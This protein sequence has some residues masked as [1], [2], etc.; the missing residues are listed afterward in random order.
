MQSIQSKIKNAREYIDPITRWYN[1]TNILCL[2][3]KIYSWVDF[4]KLK[5]ELSQKYPTELLNEVDFESEFDSFFEWEA[6]FFFSEARELLWTREVYQYWRSGG[7][8]WMKDTVGSQLDDMEYDLENWP[9][10]FDSKRDMH[11]DDVWDEIEKIKTS[12]QTLK[13][14]KENFEENIYYYFRDHITEN[15][16]DWKIDEV[17]IK[18]EKYNNLLLKLA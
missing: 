2:N 8:L 12:F 1:Y 9:Y 6:S 10:Y 7:W 16:I 4:D 13:D 3:I 11:K 18:A 17:K 5:T 14:M 15:I